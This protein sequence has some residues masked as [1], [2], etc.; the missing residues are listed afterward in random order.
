M[1]VVFDSYLEQSLKAMEREKRGKHGVIHLAKIEYN[2][3]IPQQMSKFWALDK[4]KALLQKFAKDVLLDLGKSLGITVV[5]SGVVDDGPTLAR[6]YSSD[7]ESCS[8]IH[9]LELNYEE[10]DWRLIP[11]LDWNIKI[12]PYI[13]CGI[14]VS[15]DTDVLVLLTYYFKH[16]NAEGLEQLW[17]EIGTGTNKVLLPVHI[18]YRKLGEKLCRNLLKAHIGTGCCNYFS[19]IGTKK[20]ALAAR[21]EDHL[22]GFGVKGFL[23]EHQFNV[24]EKYLVKAYNN[25]ATEDTFNELRFRVWK[26]NGSVYDLPPT[27]HSVRFGDILRWWFLFKKTSSLLSPGEYDFLQPEN[28]G[29]D[30]VDNELQPQKHLKLLPDELVSTCACKTGCTSRRCK[31]LKG[32]FPGTDFCICSRCGNTDSARKK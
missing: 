20:S 25:N 27:S 5:A 23:D 30:I 6:I 16:F 32:G 21:P 29:W 4:N 18:L 13:K 12:F 28:Y 24:A 1:H 8:Y 10:A 7:T 9:D 19:K 11:H 14:V 17:L 31:C 15:N 3:P 26:T 22:D 2:T